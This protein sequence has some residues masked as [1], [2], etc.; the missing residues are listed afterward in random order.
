MKNSFWFE[1][2]W[3]VYKGEYKT[4]RKDNV[5]LVLSIINFIVGLIN[6]YLNV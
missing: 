2:N 1:Y 6:L 4:L 5:L 3:N